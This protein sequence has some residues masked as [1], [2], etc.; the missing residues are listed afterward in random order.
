MRRT[1]VVVGLGLVVGA[2]LLAAPLACAAQADDHASC[3]HRAQD[4]HAAG[5]DHRHD[6][7]TGMAADTSV[8]HFEITSRGGV[9]RLEAADASDESGRDQARGHLEHVA[10]SFAAGDFAMPMF[11]HGQTPPGAATMARLK[12]SIRYRYEPTDRG[13]RITIDTSNH[14]ARQAI[15]DFLRFQ[16]RDHRTRD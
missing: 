13:G 4:A 3:P 12:E 10:S 9:I 1:A 15:H 6:E 16:I 8:H 7:T 11:I 2:G 14:E 5:V